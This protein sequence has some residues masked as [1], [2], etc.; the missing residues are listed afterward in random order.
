VDQEEFDN[1]RAA[2]LDERIKVLDLV[3]SDKPADSSNRA[4]LEGTAHGLYCAYQ[5]L[6]K[7][8]T[9]SASPSTPQTDPPHTPESTGD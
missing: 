3:M 4:F 1:L 2:I 7:L 6:G 8:I 9:A 5:I